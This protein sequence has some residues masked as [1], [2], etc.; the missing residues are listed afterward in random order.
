MF[1]QSKP[2]AFLTSSLPS[3]SSLLKLPNSHNLSLPLQPL[4][5]RT[6]PPPPRPPKNPSLRE[7]WDQ[8]KKF[9]MAPE[10]YPRFS[11]R[12]ELYSDFNVCIELHRHGLNG[13]AFGIYPSSFGSFT[14]TEMCVF[15]GGKQAHKSLSLQLVC[16]PRRC[17]VKH[18]KGRLS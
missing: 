3:P 13:L 15:S 9:K 6:P 2:V 14:C 16:W 12:D 17:K 8:G 4:H 7:T 1:C 11:E 5:R 10:S 18:I